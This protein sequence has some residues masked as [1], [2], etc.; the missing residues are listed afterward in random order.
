MERF[1]LAIPF[2]APFDVVHLALTSHQGAVELTSPIAPLADTNDYWRR[3]VAKI[4][5][6]P[7]LEDGIANWYLGFVS[8]C[9]A[10]YMMSRRKDLLSAGLKEEGL[11]L[12]SDSMLCSKFI[13][14][15]LQQS[16]EHVVSQMVEMNFYFT[17]TR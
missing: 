8:N 6:S 13:D 11:E 10:K 15:S 12:R 7:D 3:A 14:G 5:T 1:A 16:V 4:Y 17:Q 2:L 9:S